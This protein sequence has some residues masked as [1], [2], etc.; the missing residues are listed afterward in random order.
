MSD[1]VGPEPQYEVFAD[2]FLDQALDGFY[3]AHYDRPVCL[4]LLGTVA[5]RRVLDA[6]CG[7]GL[8]A[9]ALATR[10]AQ[11]IGFDHSTRMRD[12]CRERIPLGE[13]RVHDLTSPLDWLPDSSVDL[14]LI[15][16]AIEYVDDRVA[17][18]R[19]LHR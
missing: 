17:A 2:E 7:P 1:R 6:T 5:G 4:E 9:E 10:G 19:E 14:V 13:F 15:A 12:L 11:V 8:Y 16:L 3:N 18:L